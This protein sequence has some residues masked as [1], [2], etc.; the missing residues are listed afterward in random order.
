MRWPV[1]QGAMWG[2]GAP[3][4]HGGRRRQQPLQ[5]ITGGCWVVSMSVHTAVERVVYSYA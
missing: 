5:Q 2:E 3:S 4:A 1:S